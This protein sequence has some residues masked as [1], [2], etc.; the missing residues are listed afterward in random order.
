MSDTPIITETAG[1]WSFSLPYAWAGGYPTQDKALQAAKA[2]IAMTRFE[3][4]RPIT[5][6]LAELGL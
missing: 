3:D 5:E 4:F 1:K 2:E 6:R